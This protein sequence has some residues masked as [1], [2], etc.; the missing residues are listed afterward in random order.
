MCLLF[1][2]SNLQKIGNVTKKRY[3]RLIDFS[4]HLKKQKIVSNGIFVEI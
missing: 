1:P 2:Q 3:Q 4:S